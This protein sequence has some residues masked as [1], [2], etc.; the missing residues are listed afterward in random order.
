L[1]SGRHRSP[2]GTFAGLGNNHTTRSDC[3]PARPGPARVAF[4]TCRARKNMARSE[5]WLRVLA[6]AV[7]SMAPAGFAV[8]RSP[9]PLPIPPRCEN[10]RH[11][12][13][14]PETCDHH[15]DDRDK[16]FGHQGSPIVSMHRPLPPSIGLRLNAASASNW[17]RSPGYSAFGATTPATVRTRASP[18]RKPTWPCCSF[19][20]SLSSATASGTRSRPDV[21]CHARRFRFL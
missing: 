19:C 2:F 8:P 18:K 3:F 14:C 15:C 11:H 17:R 4:G 1:I 20:V 6:Y 21:G 5:A 16:G 13:R 10:G 7:Q 9:F 12:H